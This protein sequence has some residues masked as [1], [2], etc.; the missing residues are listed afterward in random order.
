V[1]PKAEAKQ[2]ANL[3]FKR[4]MSIKEDEEE[5]MKMKNENGKSQNEANHNEQ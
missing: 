3:A 2:G 4:Q 1:Q 5:E